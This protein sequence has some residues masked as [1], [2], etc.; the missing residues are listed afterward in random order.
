VSNAEDYY[1]AVMTNEN[2][3]VIGALF[4]LLMGLSLAMIPV[5]LFPLLR[6][7]NEV[8]AIGYF[9][10]RG[11]L[12][13]ITYIGMTVCMLLLV[14]FARGLAENPD[15]YD[16]QNLAS[17]VMEVQDA[18]NIILIIMFSLGGLI[19]YYLLFQSKLTPRWLSV[20]GIIG[21]LLHLSTAFLDLF[22]VM[23]SSMSGGTMTLNFPIFL[24]EMVMAIWL[25]V[26]GFD[27]SAIASKLNRKME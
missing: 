13:T 4:I 25:I 9:L 20:W 12:E 10:F 1:A 8:L 2:L 15:T 26:K 7:F 17:N 14:P 22:G 3:V 11:V 19:L 27:Q 24:Q 5:V 23:D 18:I 21:I 16:Y 6:I